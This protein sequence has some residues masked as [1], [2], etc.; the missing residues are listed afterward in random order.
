M[1]QR[2]INVATGNARRSTKSMKSDPKRPPVY[3]VFDAIVTLDGLG[4]SAIGISISV[5]TINVKIM[6]SALAWEI[7]MNV[8]VPKVGFS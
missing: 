4:Y 3:R 7:V 1:N 5:N 2:I 6:H 8:V